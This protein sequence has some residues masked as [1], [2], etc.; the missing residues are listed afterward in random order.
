[1]VIY[2]LKKILQC[3]EFLFSKDSSLSIHLM[4]NELNLKHTQ[5]FS[6]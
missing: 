6:S 1:M 4:R 2:K 3:K 5:D